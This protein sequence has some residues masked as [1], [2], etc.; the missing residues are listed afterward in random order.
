MPLLLLAIAVEIVEGAL[1]RAAWEQAAQAGLVARAGGLVAALA[2]RAGPQLTRDPLGLLL[3]AVAAGLAVAYLAAALTGAGAR[4][5]GAL[6]LAAALLVVLVPTLVLVGVSERTG[7]VRAQDPDVVQARADA[8]RLVSGRSPYTLPPETTPRGREV[9]ASSFRLDPPAEQQPE[10]ALLPPGPSLFAA[11]GRL[12]GQRDPRAVTLLAVALLAGLVLAA[13]RGAGREAALAV[14]L[15]CPPLALGTALGS[16][17]ALGAAGL[18]AVWLAARSGR[19]AL[20]G[21]L[22]GVAVAVDHAAV[23]AVVPLLAVAPALAGV[24][25][26]AAWSAL[27]G[28]AALAAPVALLDPAAFLARAQSA[29]GIGPGL[30]V[31]NLFVYR[32]AEASGWA[33]AAALVSPL[34]ALLLVVVLARRTRAAA[35]AA[36]VGAL[37]AVVLAPALA[38]DAVF[39][40]IALLTLA[41]V[42][43]GGPPAVSEPLEG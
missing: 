40:P 1:F 42:E 5:R 14:A 25:G 26:R 16:T 41:A 3:G 33:Q 6:R 19:A 21:A 7:L 27:A 9:F 8:G 36:G 12:L 4:L 22:A 31:F 29:T 32:G 15:L 13:T 28:Y 37:V 34:V 38:A 2:P 20:A 17:V 39:L 11:A 10:R 23:L 24:R 43:A 18:L 35:A 30:G